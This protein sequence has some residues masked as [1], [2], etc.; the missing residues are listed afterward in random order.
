MMRSPHDGLRAYWA[1]VRWQWLQEH[2]REC[3]QCAM[4]A[5]ELPL[6]DEP[7]PYGRRIIAG[8]TELA[9]DDDERR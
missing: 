8:Y 1:E 2:W 4:S 9:L 7:C 6:V 5:G 3:L